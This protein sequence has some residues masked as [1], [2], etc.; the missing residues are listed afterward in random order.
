MDKSKERLEI[1]KQLI[2]L[3]EEAQAHM[4]LEEAVK[5]VSPEN[6]GKKVKGLPYT[7][8]QLLEHLR[9]AQHDILDFSRDAQYE[10]MKWPDDYWPKEKGPEVEQDWNNS[11]KS[12]LRDRKTFIQLLKETPDLLKP[13]P[14]GSGQ[15]MVRE[16][17]LIA[18]HTA[19]HV[20]QIVV[21]RRILKDFD[22]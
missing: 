1:E 5:T 9:I 20:G 7:L 15:N 3:L 8:W 11:L 10:S 12:I 6:Y 4:S 21:I 22:H 17:M 14:Y 13:F 2:A 18:D 19:Y 16:A